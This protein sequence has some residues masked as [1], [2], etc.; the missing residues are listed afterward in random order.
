MGNRVVRNGK[1]EHVGRYPKWTYGT[2][3]GVETLV[4]CRSIVQVVVQITD[5]PDK[6]REIRLEL[7][8]GAVTDLK[9]RLDEAQQSANDFNNDL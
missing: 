5:G 4:D 2:R 6:G 8:S 9:S 1:I 7:D 3:D